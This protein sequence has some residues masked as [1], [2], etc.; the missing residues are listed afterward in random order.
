MAGG[1]IRER[2]PEERLEL[3]WLSASTAENALYSARLLP[4]GVAV[5][6]VTCDWHLQRA[7]ACFRR[8][9]LSPQGFGASS[10]RVSPG[11]R[12]RRRVRE[13]LSFWLDR[14]ATWEA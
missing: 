3:E 14:A 10:P 2:V 11:F 13:R 5:G 1:L 12:F 7:L 8:A 9:G 6:V 4:R